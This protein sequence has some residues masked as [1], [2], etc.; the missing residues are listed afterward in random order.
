MADTHI[1][2]ISGRFRVQSDPPAAPAIGEMFWDVDQKSVF[3]WTGNN[4]IGFKFTASTAATEA[5]AAVPGTGTHISSLTFGLA[6]GTADPTLPHDGSYYYDTANNSLRVYDGASGRW[7]LA[8]FT[9]TT[10]T[11]TSSTTTSTSTTT[12]STSS[13]TSTSTSTSST[14]STTTTL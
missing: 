3:R 14:T 6:T 2:Q 1:S 10:S 12:T 4:W 8:G 11:S 5:P 7:Y 13:S 9:T